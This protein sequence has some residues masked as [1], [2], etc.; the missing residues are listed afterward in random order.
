MGTSQGNIHYIRTFEITGFCP[1]IKPQRIL[2]EIRSSRLVEKKFE[3]KYN[4]K[5]TASPRL[6][7]AFL[8]KPG[9]GPCE[10]SH[11]LLNTLFSWAA[12]AGI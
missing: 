2:E 12:E 3:I 5:E 7:A 1:I 10:I 8:K 4:L 6:L 9:T 11:H